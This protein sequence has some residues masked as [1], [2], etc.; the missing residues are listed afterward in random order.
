MEKIDRARP[1][2]KTNK[3]RKSGLDLTMDIV[4]YAVLTIMAIVMLYPF[5]YVLSTSIS[6]QSEVMRGNV[7]LWPIGFDTKAYQSMI[8][9]PLFARSYLNTVIYAVTGT[10]ATLFITA[11]SAY[12]LSRDKFR[13]RKAISVLYVI[14]MFFGGGMIPTYLIIKM[15]GMVDTL[16][17][18]IL[19]GSI[20]AWNLLIMR[21][22]FKTIPES[23]HE[24]A[25]LDGAKDWTVLWKIVIPLSMPVMTT[26]GLFAMVGF[27]NDFFAALIY[28]ND[29]NKYPVQMVLRM[30]LISATFTQGGDQQKS[31]DL[32]Q[33]ISTQSLKSAAIVIAIVPIMCVYPFIQK[34][35]VKGIMIGSIKG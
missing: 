16:W 15:L 8:V 11:I 35:F 5:I 25:F 26:I 9:H 22:F 29:P 13:S 2:H 17:A 20:S 10:L 18:I 6:D 4:V 7:L 30:I 12:P 3:I 14:T 28:L 34:Y 21:S 32:L 33:A 1:A 24:S 19:P 27:W 31:A 23:L